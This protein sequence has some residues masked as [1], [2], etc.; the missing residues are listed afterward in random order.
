MQEQ[1]KLIF[2]SSASV[3][4]LDVLWLEIF[5]LL[6]Y[7]LYCVAKQITPGLS[8]IQISCSYGLSE[9]LIFLLLD[10]VYD[11]H[12]DFLEKPS[13]EFDVFAILGLGLLLLNLIFYGILSGYILFLT[14]TEM[15]VPLPKRYFY[16]YNL[17]TFGI[18]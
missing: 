16:W 7:I 10:F 18:Q 12:L 1:P 6:N 2:L 14:I 13:R 15:L 17:L 3:I 9:V 4:L 8:G 11:I 5:V